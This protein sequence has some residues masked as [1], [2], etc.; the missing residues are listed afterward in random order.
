MALPGGGGI[1][2][3]LLTRIAPCEGTDVQRSIRVGFA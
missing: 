2:L 3:H 1:E